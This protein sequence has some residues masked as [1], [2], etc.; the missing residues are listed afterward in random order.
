MTDSLAGDDPF[1]LNDIPHYCLDQVNQML[2]RFAYANWTHDYIEGT[3]VMLY[4]PEN[5]EKYP[6][7]N[8]AVFRMDLHAER[9]AEI[10]RDMVDSYTYMSPDRS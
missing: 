8:I 10:T 2:I 6:S 7:T 3:P 9:I 4:L 5:Q 1:T